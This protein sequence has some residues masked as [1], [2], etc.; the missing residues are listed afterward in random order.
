MFGHLK[1]SHNQKSV[2]KHCINENK[3]EY[4]KWFFHNL[5]FPI[6]IIII[7]SF[8]IIIFRDN[9]DFV[10][11][12]LGGGISLLGINI[13]FAM[14]SYLIRSKT[15]KNDELREDVLGLLNKLND[16]KVMLIVVGSFLYVLPAFY[17]PEKWYS[18]GIV[19]LVGIIIMSISIRVGSHIFIIRDELYQKAYELESFDDNIRKDGQNKHGNNWSK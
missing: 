8:L 17:K 1:Y 9:E 16:Y 3:S 11:H 4:E 6:S 13:L 15:Y 19:L 18:I 12:I 2:I 10:N 5:L 7:S 14:S